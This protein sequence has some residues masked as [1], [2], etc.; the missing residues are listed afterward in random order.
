MSC[1]VFRFGLPIHWGVKLTEVE[2]NVGSWSARLCAATDLQFL[3][4]PVFVSSQ[5]SRAEDEFGLV[6]CL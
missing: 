5:G 3:S 1:F 4:V 2:G 6:G